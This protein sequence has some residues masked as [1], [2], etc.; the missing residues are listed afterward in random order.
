M[1][2]MLDTAEICWTCR[3]KSL[4]LFPM[5]KICKKKNYRKKPQGDYENLY[6]NN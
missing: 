1:L 4:V 3:E 6:G 5:N 2:V